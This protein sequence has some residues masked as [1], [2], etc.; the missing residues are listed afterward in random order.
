MTVKDIVILY[1]HQNGFDGLCGDEC[2]CGIDE[3]I[4]CEAY[5]MECQP[6]YK[7]ECN[8]STCN[9]PCNGQLLGSACYQV[10]RG[11]K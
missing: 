7:T 11:N 8:P 6:A 10:D 9:H 5:C 2:G 1:L 3:I 4:L